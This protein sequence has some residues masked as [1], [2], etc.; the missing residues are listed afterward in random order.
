MA[1]E[2]HSSAQCKHYD[3]C[4]RNVEGSPADGLCILH[5]TDSA[6]DAHAFDKALATHRERKG[7]RFVAFVF[8]GVTDFSGVTFSGDTDFSGVTFSRDAD[9]S[10][11]TF[12]RDADF[13]ITFSGNGLYGVTFSGKADFR[14]VTF[15]GAD[16]SG[17]TFSGDADFSAA[18]FSGADFH[19]A[20]FSRTADF[21]GAS[22]SEYAFFHE[23]TFSGAADF[24]GVTFSGA[25]YFFKARFSGRTLFR[26]RQ[27]GTEDDYIFAGTE[28]DFTQVFI[29]SPDAV[30]FQDAD[31]TKCRFLN[32]DLRKV[33][34]V[35]V[36]W[37]K[38]VQRVIVKWWPE[39]V[40]RVIVKWWPK[41]VQQ[42]RL[43]D[44]EIAS[45]ETGD[46]GRR[47]WFQIER[48]YRDLKQNYEDRRDYERAGDFHYGEKETRRQ[49]PDTARGLRFFLTLYWLFSGYGELYLRP[50]F[51]AGVL[52]VGSTIGYM[53][54]GLRPKE[55][56]STLAWTNGWDWFQGTYYSFRVMMF[57]KPEDWVPV[58]YTHIINTFQTLLSPLFLGLFALAL[59]QRLKR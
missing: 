21:Q 24:S 38:K 40:Q 14:G 17:V 6:K 4:G 31:L 13:G 47:P 16:F 10:G 7:D 25:A 9:F 59:R 30:T 56:G 33:Q 23:T 27:G 34:L 20:T 49:N 1:N 8:P 52:F 39:K 18:T 42:G 43:Y 26:G 53:W 12:S 44:D 5:S 58:G 22:L 28:V 57:L 54:W 15:S 11:V 32:T 37:P 48:L 50:L 46:G 29:D 35:G 3:I 45:V 2:E 55:G 51:W 19:R 36:N 41:K